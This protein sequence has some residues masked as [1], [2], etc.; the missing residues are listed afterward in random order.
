MGRFAGV[1][2]ACCFAV[3]LIIASG[4]PRV[5][6]A[7]ESEYASI[8]VAVSIEN[9]DDIRM[10]EYVGFFTEGVI[11]NRAVGLVTSESLRRIRGHGYRVTIL[12]E[13]IRSSGDDALGKARATAYHTFSEILSAMAKVA[14]DYPAIAAFDTCGYSVRDRPVVRLTIG[15]D[16]TGA[17]GFPRYGILGGVHGHEKIGF[18]AV[19][20]FVHYLTSSYSSDADVKAMVD[21]SAFHIFPAVNPDGIVN[22]SRENAN[23][24]DINRDY[25]LQPGYSGFMGGGSL[26]PFAQPETRALESV[27][28]DAPWLGAIDFHSGIIAMY[29]SWFCSR[30]SAPPDSARFSAL[31]LAYA[32][33]ASISEYGQA[34]KV[35]YTGA[36]VSCD[37]FYGKGGTMAFTAE[38][39]GGG[40]GSF[41][42][43]ASDIETTVNPHVSA[44]FS[45]FKSLRQGVKGRV[46]D[47]EGNALYA[48]MT[49]ANHGG[50]VFSA[51]SSGA[52]YKYL[53]SSGA[54]TV[55]ALANGY[56]PREKTVTLS[57][58]EFVE[59]NFVLEA[60]AQLPYYAMSIE[61]MRSAETSSAVDWFAAPL[62]AHDG[63]G[64]ALSTEGPQIPGM[65]PNSGV[66]TTELTLD[67]GPGTEIFDSEGD[68]F[69]VYCAN[70]ADYWAE[71]GERPEGPWQKV[72]ERNGTGSF[73]IS[74][75][76]LD[77]ARYVRFRATSGAPS[78][79]AVE[80]VANNDIVPVVH[81][82]G[83]A[84]KLAQAIFGK[85]GS[86][87]IRPGSENCRVEI[88]DMRGKLLVAHPI[89]AGKNSE[90]IEISPVS[91]SGAH[92]IGIHSAANRSAYKRTLIK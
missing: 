38:I 86:L 70:A 41:N 74:A 54:V 5:A 64:L 75:S 52:Y 12:N 21:S 24:Y 16:L 87:I 71:I 31:A 28:L 59:C 50:S 88:Y 51:P 80:A 19:L 82:K 57:S 39:Y 42:P 67:M 33:N 45:L 72:G 68:D 78:F 46:T 17:K 3:L 36:G 92:I 48:R 77:K 63:V 73:D 76:T 84:A 10:L 40:N 1:G 79:D 26:T 91:A 34:G 30:K 6:A 23:R 44:A 43:P 35:S 27:Y 66:D 32:Q 65:P 83:G 47:T 81:K 69:T 9:A 61:R 4:M 18:E 20:A 58:G 22:N 8:A 15:G 85:N 14:N 13:N 29:Y 49:V 53:A 2:M 60:D 11:G 25:G 7:A 37:Y 89:R 90:S 56:T 62:G 55:R